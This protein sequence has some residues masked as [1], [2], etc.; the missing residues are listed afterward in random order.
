MCRIKLGDDNDD[1][2]AHSCSG[3]VNVPCGGELEFYYGPNGSQEFK[4]SNGRRSLLNEADAAKAE[5][6]GVLPSPSMGGGAAD[7]ASSLE[8]RVNDA[9]SSSLR[10][11]AKGSKRI[12]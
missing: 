11:G 9:T 12:M 1:A 2:N 3:Y 6:A 8:D 10:G 4:I 5:V 7:V